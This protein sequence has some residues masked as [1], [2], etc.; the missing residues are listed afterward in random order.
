[1]LQPIVD[2]IPSAA[3]MRMELDLSLGNFEEARSDARA[4]R[5][6][7]NERRRKDAKL[8]VLDCR[9]GAIAE[10]LL[11]NLDASATWS[12]SG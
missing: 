12:E 9:S 3:V 2:K 11:G 10:E 5:V 8:S 4:V 6:H 1:M 7:M